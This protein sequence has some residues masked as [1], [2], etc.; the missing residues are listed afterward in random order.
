MQPAGPAGTPAQRVVR[1]VPDVPAIHRRFDYSV[2]PPLGRDLR[3]GSRVRVEL[4][5]RRVGAWVVEDGVVAPAGVP[6]KPLAALSGDGPPPEVV[7]LAEWA[8]WRWAGPLS[9][10]LG[11]ASP[12]RLV[13]GAW[14][15]GPR[16]TPA[17]RDGD[18]PGPSRPHRPRAAGRWPS[19]T[20]S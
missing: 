4:H 16:P 5:G 17:I 19:W 12:P 18:G 15:G 2:P 20:G 1:V 10:F 7:A 3:V 11:T 9:S 13:R 8:A 6:L 14:T